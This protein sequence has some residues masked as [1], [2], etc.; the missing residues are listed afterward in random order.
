MKRIS[1]I[2][3]FYNVEPYI[4]KCIHSLFIQDVPQEEYEVI[5]VDDCSTDGSRAIVEKLQDTY[6]TLQLLCHTENKRQGGARNTGL[7]FAR[8]EYVWF[9]DSDDYVLPNVLHTIIT[10]AERNKLDILQFNTEKTLPPYTSIM[11]GVE[12]ALLNTD[13]SSRLPLMWRTVFS[14]SFLLNNNLSF[15]EYVQFEDTDF[16]LRSY[17]VARKVQ[18]INYPAYIY[19]IHSDSTVHRTNSPTKIYEQI[20]LLC[21]TSKIIDQ[22][23]DIRYDT[24]LKRYLHNELSILGKQI[25]RLTFK[26]RL[27]YAKIAHAISL[28]RLRKYTSARN[29]LRLRFGLCV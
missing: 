27:L 20:L 25:S 12:Y 24:L 17:L 6:P 5:C 3:P 8:G 13:W 16:A 22:T 4:E 29:L 15:V 21:R 11:N 14:R 7:K 10:E 18:F 26:D 1:I 28:R 9:V 19:C 23:S 2:V